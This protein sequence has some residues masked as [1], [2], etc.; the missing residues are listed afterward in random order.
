MFSRYYLLVIIRIFTLHYNQDI[1]FL[2]KEKDP[3]Q[4]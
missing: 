2:I 1:S 3:V 4:N